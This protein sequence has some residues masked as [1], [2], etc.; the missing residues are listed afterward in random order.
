L[1]RRPGADRVALRALNA[2]RRRNAAKAKD[3]MRDL[4]L[5]TLSSRSRSEPL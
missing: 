1:H 3:P 2:A 4:F 5:P